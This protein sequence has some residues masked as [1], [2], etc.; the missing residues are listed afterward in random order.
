ML[1]A[2]LFSFHHFVCLEFSAIIF[3]FSSVVLSYHFILD[4]F[5]L[6]MPK[7]KKQLVRIIGGPDNWLNDLPD[8]HGKFPI[9]L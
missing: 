5:I 4:L 7:Q 6:D 9:F 3:V 8:N 1:K 2:D